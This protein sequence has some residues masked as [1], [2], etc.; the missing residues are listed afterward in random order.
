MFFEAFHAIHGPER[1]WGLTLESLA[2]V[3]AQQ[4]HWDQ[5]IIFRK[6]TSST[7]IREGYSIPGLWESELP[8]LD[9]VLAWGCLACGWPV[10]WSLM[11]FCVSA[12]SVDF[13]IWKKK[14]QPWY[15]SGGAGRAPPY[16]HS[17]AF[18][19]SSGCS[20]SY[21][22]LVLQRGLGSPCPKV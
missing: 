1:L 18:P 14:S 12:G 21:E 4:W 11:I 15:Q 8:R 13:P 16:P 19:H 3:K 5:S 2:P 20:V 10:S 22:P 17:K 7:T 6:V 9:L